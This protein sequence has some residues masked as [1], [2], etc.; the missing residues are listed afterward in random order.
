M[1]ILLYVPQK[2]NEKPSPE[3][4]F[5]QEFPSFLF[6]DMKGLL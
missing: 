3:L 6:K 4:H 1:L 5:T 2:T